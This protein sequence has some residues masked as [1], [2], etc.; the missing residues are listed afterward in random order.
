M[1][2][3][4]AKALR[5]LQTKATMPLAVNPAGRGRGG[6]GAPVRS[7]G[8]TALPAALPTVG[9]F[10]AVQTSRWEGGMERVVWRRAGASIMVAMRPDARCH[11]MWQWKNQMRARRWVS[12]GIDRRWEGGG[13]R[14]TYQDCPL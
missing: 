12:W 13:G 8:S 10:W 2:A 14:E 7:S 3:M 4:P 5:Q 11:S 6:S 9:M 1:T